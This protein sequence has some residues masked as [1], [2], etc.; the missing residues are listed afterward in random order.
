MSFIGSKG[1]LEETPKNRKK[2]EKNR[3]SSGIGIGFQERGNEEWHQDCSHHRL[4]R[5]FGQRICRETS[6]IWLVEKKTPLC[7]FSKLKRKGQDLM[8]CKD[9]PSRKKTNKLPIFCC[10]LLVQLKL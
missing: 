10:K 4:C 5:R 9:S 2:G 3:N 7:L 6:S 8:Q 1:A